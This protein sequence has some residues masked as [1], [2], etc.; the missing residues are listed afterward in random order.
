MFCSDPL[1]ARRV[2]THFTAEADA[3]RAAGGTVTLIDHDA[4]LRGDADAAVQR[5]PR[6]LGP[7]GAVALS[8]RAILTPQI[9]RHKA[10]DRRQD[11][12]QS[13]NAAGNRT[14]LS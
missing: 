3:A 6:D 5:V 12:H 7:A 1:N 4:L 8:D 2:D 11:S 13:P 14:T 9:F 10:E